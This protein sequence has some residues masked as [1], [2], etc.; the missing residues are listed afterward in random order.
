MYP[1]M[2][3]ARF[4]ASHIAQRHSAGYIA[5][6]WLIVHPPP[7]QRNAEAAGQGEGTRLDGVTLETKPTGG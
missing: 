4:S 6:V 2:Q 7:V 5:T 1:S 3:S